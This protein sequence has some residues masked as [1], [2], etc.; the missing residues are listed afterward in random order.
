MKVSQIRSVQNDREFP[1][2]Y[3][4]KNKEYMSSQRQEHVPIE[5]LGRDK[6]L[7]NM[8]F[9]RDQVDKVQEMS[10]LMGHSLQFE[11]REEANIVQIIVKERSSGEVVKEI[12]PERIVKFLE[13]MKELLGS[14]FDEKF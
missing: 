7:C 3:E 13:G 5:D 1:F 9:L 10:D 12:P 6:L 2:S 8:S 14:L 4:K 11:V